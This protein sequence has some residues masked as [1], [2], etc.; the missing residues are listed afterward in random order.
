[1]GMGSGPSGAARWRLSRS[2]GS[3]AVAI[4]V[5]KL[6]GMEAVHRLLE[7]NALVETLAHV[8]RRRLRAGRRWL[9][10]GADRLPQVVGGDRH[11][12]QVPHRGQVQGDAALAEVA[13]GLHARAQGDGAA[14]QVLDLAIDG[15]AQ[16]VHRVVTDVVSD[17]VRRT[18]F[19]LHRDLRNGVRGAR[20]HDA[21]EDAEVAQPALGV[22]ELARVQR[23]TG[24]ELRELDAHQ[25]LA[26]VPDAADLDRADGLGRPFMDVE[27]EAEIGPFLLEARIHADGR[28]PELEV[29][30]AQP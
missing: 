23:L 10:R 18:L 16:R 4:P 25:P 15:A 14:E 17:V 20:H 13:A 6:E 28:M 29:V 19:Q 7:Q 9:E 24:L 8:E 3:T 26:G 27:D 1:M 5:E 12:A 30:I 2:Q 22:G 21:A 11:V